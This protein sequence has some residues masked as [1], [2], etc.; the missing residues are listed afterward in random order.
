M[1]NITQVLTVFG[2]NFYLV[3]V[4][5]VEILIAVVLFGMTITKNIRSSKRKLSVRSVESEFLEAMGE[6]FLRRLHSLTE[7]ECPAI[8]MR[9]VRMMY[10][11]VS[12]D[13]D[14]I[15]LAQYYMDK[16]FYIDA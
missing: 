7:C 5:C 16:K 15:G 10:S 11:D 3:V 14:N 2:E 8:L 13:A 12:A 1:S 9:G 6:G 4:L